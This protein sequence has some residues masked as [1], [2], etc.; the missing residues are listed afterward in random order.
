[1]KPEHAGSHFSNVL[2]TASVLLAQ[3]DFNGMLDYALKA[4]L[5]GAIWLGYKLIADLIDKKKKQ[6]TTNGNHG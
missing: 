3:V 2:L 4:S 1:M 5:G 6:N